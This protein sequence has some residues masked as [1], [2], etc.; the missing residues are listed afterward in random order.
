[1]PAVNGRTR[2][3]AAQQQQYGLTP[4]HAPAHTSAVGCITLLKR[5]APA[6]AGARAA[7]GGA[8]GRAVRGRRREVV[9]PD[10]A[11][12]MI[13][14]AGGLRKAAPARALSL[15]LHEGMSQAGMVAPQAQL[16]IAATQ[17]AAPLLP[18][19][20]TCAFVCVGV[21]VSCVYFVCLY[22]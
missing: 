1:M 10:T 12:I 16:C 19:C 22:V 13:T 15:G 3:A 14:T 2:G 20:I 17:S 21:C 6:G 8:R 11:A 18:D 4:A 9:Q 5:E 7:A